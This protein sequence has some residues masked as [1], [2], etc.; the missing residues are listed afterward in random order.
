[1]VANLSPLYATKAALERSGF[2]VLE[3]ATIRGLSGFE[4]RFDFVAIKEGRRI[5]ISVRRADPLPIVLELAKALDVGNEVV[6]AVC[7]TLPSDLRAPGNRGRVKLVEFLETSELE[8]KL[9]NAL[10]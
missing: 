3:N 4:H 9:L 6:I 7:G 2:K 5:A 10:A 8:E 1:V